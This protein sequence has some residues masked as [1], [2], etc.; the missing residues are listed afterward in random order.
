MSYDYSRLEAVAVRLIARFGTA[1]T[2]IQR[3][4]PSG[5]ANRPTYGPDVETAIIAVSVSSMAKDEP[6]ETQT[7]EELLVSVSGLLASGISAGDKVVW[8]GKTMAVM[9][10]EPLRPAAT[11]LYWKVTVKHG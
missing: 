10:V 4:A 3:G 7:E 9:S 11:A 6:A 8:Q 1:G 5:P 2:L